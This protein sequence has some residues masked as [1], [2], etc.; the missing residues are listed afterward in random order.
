[1]PALVDT[2][3]SAIQ[4]HQDAVKAAQDAAQ[5]HYEQSTPQPQGQT[6]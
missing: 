3:K 2:L 1:M 4:R 5:T 6:K